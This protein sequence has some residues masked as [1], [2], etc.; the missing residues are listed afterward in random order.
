MQVLVGAADQARHLGPLEKIIDTVDIKGRADLEIIA[1]I[2]RPVLL[3]AEEATVHFG[4]E[5]HLVAI[6][7]EEGKSVRYIQTYTQTRVNDKTR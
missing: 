5:L 1:P 7:W 3:G 4:V 2:T 6:F